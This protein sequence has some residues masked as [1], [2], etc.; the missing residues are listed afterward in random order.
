MEKITAQDLYAQLYDL[1]VFD[2]PGEVDFYKELIAL[3]PEIKTKGVLE[4]GCGTGRI[5]LRIAQNGINI[6][7]LDLS[8]EL[9][10]IARKKSIGLPNIH[11]VNGDMRKFEIG[12]K[13]GAVIIPGHSFQFMITPDDQVNCL[14]QIKHHL[15]AD[16]LLIIHIGHQS[17]GW[18]AGL[19]DQKVPVFEKNPIMTNPLTGQKFRYSTAWTFEPSTQTAS[20]I[21]KIEQLGTNDR[22]DQT[23]EM[24][25]MP[26]HCIFRFEMEHLL[27]CEGFSIEAVYGDF[28]K[29]ELCNESEDMIWIARN[30]VG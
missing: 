25:P 27:R 23:W 21:R 13:F 24:E 28:Y 4:I 8:S 18:L 30:R 22:V 16:G 29:N 1:W 6:T 3:S 12:K 11:W 14:E 10:E 2:W 9:L 17:I 20:V 5:A 26:L 7:G 15:V 19:L